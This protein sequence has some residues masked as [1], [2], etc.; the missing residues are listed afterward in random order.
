MR[1]RSWEVLWH[2]FQGNSIHRKFPLIIKFYYINI[3]NTVLE[4]WEFV[5][6]NIKFNIL[7]EI[8]HQFL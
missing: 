8:H 2:K 3:E 1:R 6:K 7:Y 5:N 4:H